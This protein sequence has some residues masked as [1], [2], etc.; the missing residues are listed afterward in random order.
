M[1]NQKLRR[2]TDG[3]QAPKIAK[4]EKSLLL[5]FSIIILWQW[6]IGGRKVKILTDVNQNLFNSGQSAKGSADQI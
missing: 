2:H 1:T 6:F 3:D 5:L 4:I